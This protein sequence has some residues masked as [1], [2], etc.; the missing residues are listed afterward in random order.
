VETMCSASRRAASALAPERK[1]LWTCVSRTEPTV[2]PCFAAFSTYAAG[3]PC[4]STTA[5]TPFVGQPT[6]YEAQAFSFAEAEIDLNQCMV[7]R[8]GYPGEKGDELLVSAEEAADLWDRVLE[9]GVVSCGLGARDTLRLEV[10]LT[11]QRGPIGKGTA[12]ATVDGALACE[13]ELTFAVDLAGT[14]G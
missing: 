6:R 13:G 5:H 9:R 2:M 4:G 14:R 7:N 3:S 8:T 12:R 1:S 10:E 11:R